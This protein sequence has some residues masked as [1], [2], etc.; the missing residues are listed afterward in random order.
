MANLH[1]HAH[2][3]AVVCTIAQ[4]L[5][6]QQGPA[7]PA[8]NSRCSLQQLLRQEVRVGLVCGLVWLMV[9]ALQ[10]ALSVRL[11]S[12]D[13]PVIGQHETHTDTGGLCLIGDQAGGSPAGRQG[14]NRSKGTSRAAG[15]KAGAG[16]GGTVKAAAAKLGLPPLV[17]S[18]LAAAQQKQVSGC[19]GAL[20]QSSAPPPTVQIVWAADTRALCWVCFLPCW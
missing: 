3:G 12:R 14:K 16:A 18:L 11:T 13:Q 2:L 15:R 5:L 17:T 6:C 8:V 19:C 7:V 9:E 4:L 10:P 1:W 20:D